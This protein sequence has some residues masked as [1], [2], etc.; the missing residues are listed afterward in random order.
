MVLDADSSQFLALMKLA[1]E[2]NVALEGPPGSGKSQTIV[3]A[4][5]NAILSGKKVLFAAQKNTALEVVYN[6]LKALGLSQFALPLMGGHDISDKFYE[7]VKERTELIRRTSND[8]I[9]NLRSQL[10]HQ[11]ERLSSIKS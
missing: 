6:R 9:S 3:N 1:N 11:R 7:A 8:D 5:A 10:R 2:Q 4:V